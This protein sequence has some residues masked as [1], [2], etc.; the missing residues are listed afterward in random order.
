[1][2]EHKCTSCGASLPRTGTYCLACDTPVE[3]AVRGLSVGETE[4]VRTGR[5]LMGIGIAV[6]VVLV[7][8][9]LTYGIWNFMSHHADGEA[10]KAAE[11]DVTMVVLAEGGHP[12]TCPAL[13]LAVTGTPKDQREACVALA[14]DYPGAHLRHLHATSVSRRGS[15]ATVHLDGTLVDKAGKVPFDRTVTLVKQA[16][17][18]VLDWDGTA[19]TAA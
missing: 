14:R 2:D 19:I 5:P 15:R 6:G 9:G 12:S 17:N 3:D 13:S 1:V 18:W 11:A 16:G 7:V 8:G 10:A 4:V